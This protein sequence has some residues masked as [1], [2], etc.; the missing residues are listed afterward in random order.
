MRRKSVAG[1]IAI[2]AGIMLLGGVVGLGSLW[3]DAAEYERATAT[4]RKVHT[5]EVRRHTRKNKRYYR[6][7]MLLA[8]P[9][10]Q[11][12]EMYLSKNTYWPFRRVGGTVQVWYRPDNFQDVRLPNEEIVLWLGLILCGGIGLYGGMAERYR[13]K[14]E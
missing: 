12:G 1:L 3:F 8:V 9:T 13:L 14:R 7:T 10:E 4:I 5:E 11:F 6:H 2:I